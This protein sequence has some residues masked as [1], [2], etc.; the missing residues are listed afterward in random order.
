VLGF[1][2]SRARVIKA[3]RPTTRVADVAVH[4]VK[5][6]VSETIDFL[7]APEKYI[8]AGRRVRAGRSW[9]GRSLVSVADWALRRLW[10]I[11]SLVGRQRY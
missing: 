7:R 9:S 5:Q 1:N 11:R 4:G 8:T 2:K 6:E 10:P 3:E